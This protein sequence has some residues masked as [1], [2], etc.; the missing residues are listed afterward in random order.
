[1][2]TVTEYL[3][4]IN[5]TTHFKRTSKLQVNSSETFLYLTENNDIPNDCSVIRDSEFHIY[6][7]TCMMIY[8]YR[9]T[10]NIP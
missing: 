3:D 6:G 10:L 5:A 7:V 1:M 2:C 8:D 9:E 4:H